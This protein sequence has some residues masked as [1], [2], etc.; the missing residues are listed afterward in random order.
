M[1]ISVGTLRVNFT[2]EQDWVGTVYDA[3][4]FIQD[5]AYRNCWSGDDV[6]AV[7]T[8]VAGGALEDGTI[9]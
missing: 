7:K 9:I 5:P 8:L 1:Q 6:F 3:L 4:Q 2:P